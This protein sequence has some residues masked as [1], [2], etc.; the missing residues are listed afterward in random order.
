[1]WFSHLGAVTT[2]SQSPGRLVDELRFVFIMA[3]L[4]MNGIEWMSTTRWLKSYKGWEAM[5][6]VPRD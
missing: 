3:M 5:L 4:A 1:M 2:I 6:Q